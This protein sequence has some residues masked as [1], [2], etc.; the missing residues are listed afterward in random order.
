VKISHSTASKA[1]LALGDKKPLAKSFFFFL[2]FLFFSQQAGN[3]ASIRIKFSD[4]L[5]PWT[6]EN[7]PM[8][9]YTEKQWHH[10]FPTA[11]SKVACMKLKN[12]QVSMT[13]LPTLQENNPVNPLGR[14][15]PLPPAKLKNINSEL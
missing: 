6:M 10:F 2:L 11:S 13:P 8:P 14:L 1:C 4:I 15:N 7:F 9:R 5:D 3:R 12:E